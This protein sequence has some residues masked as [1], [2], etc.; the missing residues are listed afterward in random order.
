M[1]VSYTH[2]DVYKRQGQLS[3]PTWYLVALVILSMF[4]RKRWNEEEEEDGQ[5]DVYTRQACRWY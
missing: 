4:S 3:T 1:A 2:L 5:E